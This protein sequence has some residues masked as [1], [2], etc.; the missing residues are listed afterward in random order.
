MA[1]RVG[2]EADT[3]RRARRSALGVPWPAGPNLNSVNGRKQRFALAIW[4]LNRR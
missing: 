2:Y 4:M 1:E 3:R